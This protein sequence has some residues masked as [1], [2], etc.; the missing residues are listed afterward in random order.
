MLDPHHVFDC[1]GD[2]V[3]VTDDDHEF[4]SADIGDPL[5]ARVQQL[6]VSRLVRWASGPIEYSAQCSC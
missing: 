4:V 2:R 1:L 3:Q 6:S 5:M